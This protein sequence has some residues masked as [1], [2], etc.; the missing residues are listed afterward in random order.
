MSNADYITRKAAADV[1]VGDVL[2]APDG[3]GYKV[4]KVERRGEMIH[5]TISDESS[6]MA[7]FKLGG[8]VRRFRASSLLRV[9]KQ[10]TQGGNGE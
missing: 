10:D 3:W 7:I 2:V 4:D 9:A 5:L 1:V 6:S 8:V